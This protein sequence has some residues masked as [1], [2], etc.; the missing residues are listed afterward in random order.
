MLTCNGSQQS[1]SRK[2]SLQLGIKLNKP[3]YVW[4]INSEN[5]WIYAS[6][7]DGKFLGFT[8]Y[9]D[10]DN[11]P[12]TPILTKNFAGVGSRDIEN[13]S[14]LNKSTNKWEARKQYVG[15]EKEVA[16]KQAIRDVF[17]KTFNNKKLSSDEEKA[18]D[19]II[20]HCKG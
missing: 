11:N 8:P 12:M 1:T 16:A 3:V 2:K 13:Y 14:I 15:E 20:K 10:G 7:S 5:W 9:I 18:A 6:S 19:D 4:D 17:E